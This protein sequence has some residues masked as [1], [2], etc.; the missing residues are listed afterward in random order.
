MNWESLPDAE[1]SRI[2]DSS[3]QL[4]RL[5]WQYTTPVIIASEGDSDQ[6][7]NTAS[8]FVI[9]L[10]GKT[11]L[12]TAA[13]VIESYRKRLERSRY[14]YIQAA[15][16]GI[17]AVDRIAYCSVDTDV[18]FVDLTGL[19][20][21]RTESLVYRPLGAWPPARPAPGDGIQFC[22][23]PKAFRVFLDAGE[24][25]FGELPGFGAVTTAGANYCTCKIERDDV[26]GL[27][28]SLE[29]PP[30][31]AFGGLSGG[32]VLQFGN[33]AYPIVGLISDVSESFDI[34]RF[35]TLENVPTFGS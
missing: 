16:L 14:T 34:I 15:A 3:L 35:A 27:G 30:A 5:A 2:R 12:G 33:L 6:E 9:E 19:D 23:F 28:A 1:R 21:E 17:D 18:A 22:G 7:I 26:I 32:P 24:I 25:D 4:A 10:D 31:T 29:L 20:I 13:H 8:G 11:Y